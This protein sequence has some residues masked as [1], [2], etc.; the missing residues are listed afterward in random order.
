[1]SPARRRRDL[2]DRY[3]W[4][5][6]AARYYDRNTGRYVGFTQVRAAVDRMIA[7]SARRA[8]T[9]SDLLRQGQL[10]L[11]E[12]QTV[13]RD[14]IAMTHRM[15]AAAAA[16]GWA[17]LTQAD[18]GRIGAAVR[19][20]YRYLH[21]FTEA[22]R[23]GLPL[24]GRFLQRAAMYPK[25]ARPFYH[26]LHGATVEAA[27]YDEERNVLHEAEHCAQC[28]DMSALGW[29][30]VGTCIPIGRRTCLG[31]DQCTMEYRSTGS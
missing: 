9:A 29:V 1:V 12:W 24:D 4:N 5:E 15:A 31:N 10:D 8:T 18:Y 27:G 19:V 2:G 6:S 28:Q 20:Q 25:A 7:A 3:G 14:E 16:G 22:I 13:M 30:P 23:A 17:Q 11:G 21:D 26:D